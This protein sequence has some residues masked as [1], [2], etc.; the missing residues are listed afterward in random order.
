MKKFISILLCALMV[1]SLF[2]TVFAAPVPSGGTEVMSP[3]GACNHTQHG[4]TGT[5]YMSTCN[6]TM[7]TWYYRSCTGCGGTYTCFVRCPAAP[8]NP[9]HCERLPI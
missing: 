6:G 8:H 5:L 4:G 7:Q 2:A 3:H 9:G 1:M